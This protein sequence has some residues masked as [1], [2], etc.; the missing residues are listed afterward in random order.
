MHDVMIPS[1][2]FSSSTVVVV[3]VFVMWL[4][5]VISVS[6]CLDT[7]Q[8]HQTT[9]KYTSNYLSQHNHTPTDS[10]IFSITLQEIVKKVTI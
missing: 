3:V 4:A 1:T 8:S 2:V 7:T 9:H 10:Y 5:L 6:V